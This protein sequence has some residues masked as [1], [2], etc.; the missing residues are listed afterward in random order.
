[1]IRIEQE[2]IIKKCPRG[3]NVSNGELDFENI[4]DRAGWK[5]T[6]FKAPYNSDESSYFEFVVN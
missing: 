3:I 6:Y 1:M 5:V 4:F 2:E